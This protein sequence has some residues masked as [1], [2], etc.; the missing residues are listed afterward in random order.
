MA[1]VGGQVLKRFIRLT[2]GYIVSTRHTVGTVA[3]LQC[4]EKSYYY[5]SLQRDRGVTAGIL[6]ARA[7]ESFTNGFL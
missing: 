3:I 5:I 7:A 2:S 6:A 1:L 4:A